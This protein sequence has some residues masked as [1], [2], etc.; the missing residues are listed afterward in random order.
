MQTSGW[1]SRLL[2]ILQLLEKALLQGCSR[3]NMSKVRRLA[4][5]ATSKRGNS[6]L[7]GGVQPVP[8]SCHHP[9]GPLKPRVCKHCQTLRIQTGANFMHAYQRT[10]LALLGI[11]PDGIHL[12]FLSLCLPRLLVTCPS[13][14]TNCCI[15]LL[16][17]VICR[18][19]SRGLKQ[20]STTP[21]AIVFQLLI[22]SVQLETKMFSTS[23]LRPCCIGVGCQSRSL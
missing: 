14:C 17:H 15:E 4:V 9:S 7:L 3:S 5:V 10:C 1:S 21:P 20:T 16:Y 22:G 18:S 12:R 11:G 13:P 6:V 8:L 2:E 19:R 23:L